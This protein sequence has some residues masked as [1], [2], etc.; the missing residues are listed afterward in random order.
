[1]HAFYHRPGDGYAPAAGFAGIR[2]PADPAKMQDGSVA[3]PITI[4]ENAVVVKETYGML[5]II[6]GG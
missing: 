5:R 6:S 1:M 2:G 4:S 3:L